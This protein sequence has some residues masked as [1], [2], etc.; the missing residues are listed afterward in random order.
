MVLPFYY[1]LWR[2]VYRW[3]LRWRDETLRLRVSELAVHVPSL[4]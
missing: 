1:K 2:M 4:V 3:Q